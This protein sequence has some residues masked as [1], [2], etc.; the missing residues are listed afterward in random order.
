M[1]GK[2][3]GRLTVIGSKITESGQELWV[4]QCDCGNVCSMLNFIQ[5]K[6][7]DISCGCQVWVDT[8]LPKP[9]KPK[10]PKALDGRGK[11]SH[12]KKKRK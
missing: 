9:K 11:H 6:D 2:R 4:C 12:H 8:F 7:R 3:F 1:L 10:L 5:P